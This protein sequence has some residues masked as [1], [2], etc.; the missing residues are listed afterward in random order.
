MFDLC[1]ENAKVQMADE[2]IAV[3]GSAV[4]CFKHMHCPLLVI[5][6]HHMV[7]G[8]ENYLIGS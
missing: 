1:N 6:I 2:L 7:T 8:C 4:S 5:F 3:A